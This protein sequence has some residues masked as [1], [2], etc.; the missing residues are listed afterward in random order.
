MKPWELTETL[1][2][3]EGRLVREH[4]I[5]TYG[6]VNPEFILGA[7]ACYDSRITYGLSLIHI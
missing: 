5:E 3:A 6:N 7:H 1:S 2:L 4:L